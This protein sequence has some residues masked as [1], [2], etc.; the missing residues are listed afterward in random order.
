M[1]IIPKYPIVMTS[2]SAKIL[3]NLIVSERDISHLFLARNIDILPALKVGD[4]RRY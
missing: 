3:K 1:A 2:I 4:L